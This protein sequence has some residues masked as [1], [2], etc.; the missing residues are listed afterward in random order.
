VWESKG[1]LI[2]KSN[3]KSFKKRG[4]NLGDKAF[5]IGAHSSEYEAPEVGK[6]CTGYWW[7]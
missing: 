1:K 4:A 3:V 7:K 2:E 6:Y 5:Q